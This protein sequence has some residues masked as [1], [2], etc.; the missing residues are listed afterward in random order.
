VCSKHRSG[1]LAV[2]ADRHGGLAV[3]LRSRLG[4]LKVHRQVLRPF[5]QELRAAYHYSVPVDESLH[6][7]PLDVG[8]VIDRGQRTDLLDG[9]TTSGRSP[10]GL[11]GEVRVW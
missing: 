3:R 8:E 1:R 2:P 4:A 10:H 6:P 9:P 5:L 7:E 11:A